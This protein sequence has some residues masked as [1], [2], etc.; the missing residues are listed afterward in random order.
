MFDITNY[1]AK[2]NVLCTVSIQAAFDAAAAEQGTVLIP[3]GTFVTG[4]INMKGA[5]LYLAK[6]AVLKGSPDIADY[7][8]FGYV[9]NEMGDVLSLLYTMESEGITISGEGTID[10]NGSS[11]YNFDKRAIPPSK[12]SFTPK[13]IAECTAVIGK[14]PTQ[15]IFFY[16]SSHIT[17]AGIKIINAPCWTM[18]FIECRDI[19]ITDL[20]I[21]NDLTIPNNDGMHFSS[22]TDVIVRGCNISAGDD[23]IAMTAITDWNKPCERIIVSDCI[24]RSCSK[25]I[26]IGYMH[27]IIRDVTI[28]NCLIRE[29]N[30]ALVIMSSA[31]TG[32][33]ENV[34]V[35]N[36]RLDTRIRAGNWWGN[37]EPI[38]LMGTYH[39][40]ERYRDAPPARQL[41]ASIRNVYF[42]NI[43]CSGENVIAVIGE[44]N[45]VQNVSFD[46]VFFELKDS[47]NIALKG[48]IVD[49]APGEQN[50]TLPENGIPY[51]L[52]V[53]QAGK[54]RVTNVT[55]EPYKG[56][57]LKSLFE[58]CEDT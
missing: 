18:A 9:H 27:S 31:G 34:T 56:M 5:S 50:A 49:L 6:G 37:G 11:F 7:P 1:G 17:I 25:A 58:G 8:F 43:I 20:T 22:C 41:S 57:P 54:V 38:C 12:V 23:C 28:T 35:S 36:L 42:Q 48:R 14:R 21:D 52:Y 32:L 46:R 33:V 53:K 39:N 26:D 55:L 19:R 16:R 3:R 13:Q 47:D 2:E 15:P 30:R 45:S 44:N 40:N 29:S 51:W 4:T 24:L 10:L